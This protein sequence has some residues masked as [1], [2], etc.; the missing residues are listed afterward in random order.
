MQKNQPAIDNFCTT[1]PVYLTEML[2]MEADRKKDTMSNI[3]QNILEVHYGVGKWRE[4]LFH[5]TLARLKN[6]MLPYGKDAWRVETDADWKFLSVSFNLALPFKS[7]LVLEM[8]K[9]RYSLQFIMNTTAKQYRKLFRSFFSYYRD[10]V[11]N[12]DMQIVEYARFATIG[13]KRNIT[14]LQIR[15]ILSDASFANKIADDCMF[16]RNIIIRH[17]WE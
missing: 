16:L 12:R 1:L 4:K 11:M 5:D 10:G 6:E 14:A 15:E 17:K 9:A 7:E 13:F 3:L 2:Q 8:D